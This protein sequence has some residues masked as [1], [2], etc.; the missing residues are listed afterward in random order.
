VWTFM[1]STIF[2]EY[3]CDH[4]IVSKKFSRFCPKSS[5]IL[6]IFFSKLRQ[7][8]VYMWLTKTHENSSMVL[9]K[10][11]APFLA[12][13]YSSEKFTWEQRPQITFFSEK[14]EALFTWQDHAFTD[15]PEWYVA[16]LKS[17]Y[18]TQ[19]GLPRLQVGCHIPFWQLLSSQKNIC[20]QG[21]ATC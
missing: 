11:L 9:L 2:L 5:K 1:K 12:R 3:Y 15:E 14:N 18:I 8:S 17:N 20:R 10:R 7:D 21:Q 13:C 4:E 16:A 19:V 6:S